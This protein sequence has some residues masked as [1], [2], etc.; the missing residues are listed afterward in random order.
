MRF[1]TH[2]NNQKCLEWGFTTLAQG[3][4]FDLL[5]QASSWA[6]SHFIDGKTMYWVSRQ[7][8]VNQL[9]LAYKKEDTVYRTFKDFAEKGLIEY[10]KFGDK[11]FVCLTEKGKQWNSFSIR[12]S[13]DLNPTDK[14]I[15][16]KNINNNKKTTQKKF[17]RERTKPPEKINPEKSTAKKSDTDLVLLE[18]FG[19]SGQLADDFIKHR[20]ACRAVITKTAL[21]G[22]QRE[23]NKA[24]LSVAQ[25]VEYAINRGWRGFR[26]DW[27]VREESGGGFERTAQGKPKF[28]DDGTWWQGK[29][30]EIREW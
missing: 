5:N 24:G 16:N 3:A 19:V 13:S 30:I 6:E 4:L 28:S 2:I 15:N 25:A 8:V 10:V 20:K 9:P 1:T 12:N 11:D 29:T 7:M 18:Q 21:D 22:F 26:A 27:Y 17:L 23:A 14:Y